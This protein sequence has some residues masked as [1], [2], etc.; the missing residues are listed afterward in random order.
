MKKPFDFTITE[1]LRSDYNKFLRGELK[2]IDV[3][4]KYGISTYQINK[5]FDIMYYEKRK[6]LM[7][8]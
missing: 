2:V 5:L 3:K 7:P 6:E 1:E 8:I 4:T